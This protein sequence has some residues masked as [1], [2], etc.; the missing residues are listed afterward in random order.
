MK[1][2]FGQIEEVLQRAH[3]IPAAGRSQ[4]RAK[5]RNLFRVGLDLPS[6]RVGRRA[7]YSIADMLK[8]AFAA[9]ILQIGLPPEKTAGMVEDAWGQLSK[10]L[11]AVRGIIKQ[12]GGD[13][14]RLFI[15]A[16]PAALTEPWYR[17]RVASYEEI[18]TM[19]GWPEPLKASRLLI[20]DPAAMLQS[21]STAAS[22]AGL[23]LAAFEAALDHAEGVISKYFDLSEN[24]EV[25]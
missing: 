10:T 15:V 7:N 8:L 21:I 14:Q 20:I 22:A 6:G 4:F 11:F 19:I 18:E 5:L 16:E 24:L 13:R 9:E 25:D 12:R 23:D 17:F 2:R 3:G 1:L